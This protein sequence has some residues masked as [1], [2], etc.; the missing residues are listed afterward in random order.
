MCGICDLCSWKDDDAQKQTEEAIDAATEKWH[1]YVPKVWIRKDRTQRRL[2][3]DGI[4]V[5]EP[6]PEG[7]AQASDPRPSATPKSGATVPEPQPKPIPKAP[8]QSLR[9][10][11]AAEAASARGSADPPGTAGADPSIGTAGADPSGTA[12]TFTLETDQGSR[13]AVYDFRPQLS[14]L[15]EKEL[16][17][18]CFLVLS[19]VYSVFSPAK[20]SEVT[21]LMAKYTDHVSLICA[22]THKYLEYDAASALIT[23]LVADLRSGAR[24]EKD[25]HVDLEL[26]NRSLDQAILQLDTDAKDTPGDPAGDQTAQAADQAQPADMDYAPGDGGGG[27]ST[28]RPQQRDRTRSAQADRSK[29]KPKGKGKQRASSR[30]PGPQ[31]HTVSD[32]SSVQHAEFRHDLAAL[33]ENPNEPL[34]LTDDYLDQVVAGHKKH[35][36][37]A[38]KQ[39][40]HPGGRHEWP[41]GE[42]QALGLPSVTTPGE[43]PTVFVLANAEF[44]PGSLERTGAK[45]IV[46]HPGYRMILLEDIGWQKQISKEIA[47]IRPDLL[48]LVY[49]LE[50][51]DG[52]SEQAQ[53]W[54]KSLSAYTKESLVLDSLGSV[55]WRFWFENSVEGT[56]REFLLFQCRGDLG[57]GTFSQ[58]IGEVMS[59]WANQDHD[60]H[61]SPVSIDTVGTHVGFAETL[62]L[63]LREGCVEDHVAE[64][65]PVEA[66]QDEVEQS[67]TLDAIVDPR[68]NR[69][70]FM[71][72]QELAEEADFLDTLPLAGFP[73]EE[74]ERRKAWS[75]VPRRVRLGIR[76][77]P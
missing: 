20:L 4:V 10:Q 13:V 61:Y 51:Q 72:E 71:D 57:V 39:W 25:W 21:N 14:D 64:A 44:Q 11:A 2:G 5:E 30:A 49:S 67:G 58:A 7:T 45:V 24:T 59:S 77:L 46:R 40:L 19:R 42:G 18:A 29:G 73:K 41:A 75:K 48:L 74:S 17:K 62:M 70:T 28:D 60:I 52:L 22:V 35:G 6:I 65:F 23:A 27:S 50:D 68:D 54:L 26:A 15:D 53:T 36:D 66:R 43:A 33:G 76:R 56:G 3:D 34:W 1:E 16:E 32:P 31:T 47:R 63:V 37:A 9:D 55:R 8:P 38:F 12:Q 69:T